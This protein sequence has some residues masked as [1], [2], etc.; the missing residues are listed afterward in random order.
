MVD[1]TI[2]ENL[3]FE[4]ID[5][6]GRR[7]RATELLAQGGQ[8]VVYRTSDPLLLLKFVSIPASASSERAD[9]KGRLGLIAR[10][11]LADRLPVATPEAFFETDEHV[12]YV[13][14][15]LDDMEPL[16]TLMRA[17]ADVM[18]WFAATGGLRRRMR[19]LAQLADVLAAVH[20]EGLAYSDISPNNLFVSSDP[21]Q[22]TAW[23]IDTDNLRWTTTS[24]ASP[25][26]TPKF[27]APELVKGAAGNSTLTDA[28]SFATVAYQVL[29]LNHPF[30]AGKL[31]EDGDPDEMEPRAERGELPWIHDADDPS[32]LSGLGIPW[33]RTLSK[34]LR[35]L[36][37][38]TF[39]P[40]RAR[41]TERP[42]IAEW[43]EALH[44]AELILLDCANDECRH[45]FFANKATC[46]WCDAPRPAH[47]LVSAHV[48]PAPDPDI[49]DLLE[50]ATRSEPWWR[51]AV[52]TSRPTV[53][54][55]RM[56]TGEIGLPGRQAVVTL[57]RHAKGV[58][59]AP[60]PGAQ[61]SILE[62][63]REHVGV[64]DKP[65][66]VAAPMPVD[67]RLRIGK[68]AQTHII[69]KFGAK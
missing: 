1:A 65:L 15:M 47:L 16:Q 28:W 29:T 60:E 66:H 50:R 55:R 61:V 7:H 9:W 42:T 63:E 33:E 68:I 41:P 56:I 3:P 18:N 59:V 54:C 39:G 25:I 26:F 5:D 19:L 13:M 43:A 52:G 62:A 64:A 37:V 22:A 36:A 11:G 10:L 24:P 21:S 35:E 8:G 57:S 34:S 6:R 32:N 45:G 14:R 53:I 20:G 30:L 23:L 69:L 38:R 17:P 58:Y 40:G 48:A 31:V 27:G 67:R 44:R 51:A 12:G 2:S 4:V 49:P 46:P